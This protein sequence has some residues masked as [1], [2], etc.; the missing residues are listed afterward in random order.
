MFVI[1]W[2]GSNGYRHW[3]FCLLYV[4]LVARTN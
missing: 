2:E 3:N 1:T 4:C